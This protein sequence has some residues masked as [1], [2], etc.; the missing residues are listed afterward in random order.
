M[1]SSP[2]LDVPF[3][4]HGASKYSF[5]YL[6]SCCVKEESNLWP[7]RNRFQLHPHGIARIKVGKGLSNRKA[8]H[9]S[10]PFQMRA[11]VESVIGSKV[12][13]APLS[14]RKR[15]IRLRTLRRPLP[16]WSSG[17]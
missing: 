16:R 6:S 4:Q 1:L 2:Q 8:I 11:S 17:L 5:D 3:R 12:A 15:I 9:T 14:D 10:W 13:N 7:G